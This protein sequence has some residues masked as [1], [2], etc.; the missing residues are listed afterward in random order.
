MNHHLSTCNFCGVGC[1]IY[2]ETRDGEV[3]GVYPSMSHPANRGRICVRG[4]HVH[5]IASSADRL[6]QPLVRK[7]GALVPVSFDEAYDTIA[8]RLSEIKDRSGPDA[9]G[10]LDSA[11]CANE[12]AY[13]LQKFGR[14]IIGTNN[15]GQGTNFYHGTTIE[16][17]RKMLGIPAASNPIAD[18]F[19]SKVI[20]LN[21]ID[22]G[23]QLPTIGGAIIRAKL[24]GTKLIV[25]GDRNHRVA[26]HADLFL[27]IK[28]DTECFLYAAMAKIIIDRGCMDLEFIRSRCSG[29]EEFMKSIQTF[30]LL[31]AARRCDIAPS[32]IEQAA[33]MYAQS[34]P[35]MLFYAAGS[36]YIGE[37]GL[38]SMVNLVLLTGN[39]GK[40]GAGIMPLSEHN[41]AQGGC[42][43]GV[44]PQYLPG[45]VPLE[46]AVGRTR[47]E[48]IWKASI[49]LSPGLDAAG[50][51]D[52]ATP[53]KALWLDRHNPVVSA[54]YRDAGD[55]LKN[56]EFVVL[57]NLF[58][59]KTAQYAHVVLP[60]AAY[61]EEDV[62]FTSTERRIQR[63]VKA[64]SLKNGLP[65]AWQ[66]VTAVANRMGGRWSYGSSGD[67]LA[68]IAAV[69]PEYGAVTVENLTRDY[70]RQWPC[71]PDNPL[72]TSRL[73]T[74]PAHSRKFVFAN[75]CSIS[76]E[77][78]QD[79][80]F[81]FALSFGHSLYYWHQNTLIRHSETLKR[82]YGILLLDYPEGFVEINSEDAKKL[83]LRD[84]Q[85]IKLTSRTGEAH[86]FARVTSDVRGGTVYVPFF[87]Q[88][89]MKATGSQ[90]ETGRGKITHVRIEKAV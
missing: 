4:W 89:L 41:N 34:G 32:L 45:Y 36:E 27:Q 68:E 26:Q 54:G 65:S 71:T 53:L 69:I 10:L 19:S 47:I 23:Q 74:H 85:K 48:H 38:G 72:G 46:D 39:L 22:I 42:D 3:A 82:E 55:V 79:K 16:V 86:T 18:I 29:Y 8:K 67:V 17:L 51:L 44:L 7:K 33:I 56:I 40:E 58:M 57:Q 66:Q 37:N 76:P 35:G 15:I 12:D 25:V 77:E 87:I 13:L 70:G 64:V 75:I 50:M 90:N 83:T 78:A 5:E 49:P 60:V 61:G 52:Q 20:L 9:I 59:T 88:D 31:L 81:P 62:T 63:A 28:P 14:A 30:D 6:H 1:G 80:D 73:Y 2:I 24:A 21:D 11:R 84:G 43:M